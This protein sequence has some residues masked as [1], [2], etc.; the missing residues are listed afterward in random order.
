MQK[1][2]CLTNK[3]D[4]KDVIDALIIASFSIHFH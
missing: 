2:C 4:A 1:K 3:M